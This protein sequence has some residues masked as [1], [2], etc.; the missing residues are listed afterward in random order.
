MQEI[1]DQLSQLQKLSIKRNNVYEGNANHTHGML[2]SS[3]MLVMKSH[4]FLLISKFPQDR[5]KLLSLTL[6]QNQTI[7]DV[8]VIPDSKPES[9]G[10]YN[11][12]KCRY[13][14][15]LPPCA[16]YDDYDASKVVPENFAVALIIL[17]AEAKAPRSKEKI[18]TA[19]P[20]PIEHLI[21]IHQV[22]TVEDLLQVLHKV[23]DKSKQERTHFQQLTE[24]EKELPT[25]Q[26]A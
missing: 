6:H 19:T 26:L 1:R 20:I 4:L 21:N 13:P 16:D 7:F 24:T 17:D 18:P 8:V 2:N 22:A 25:D 10:N 5:S 14:K 15:R 11:K 3:N 9:A 12:S 23:K